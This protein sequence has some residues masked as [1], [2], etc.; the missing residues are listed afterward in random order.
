MISADRDPT[1]FHLALI[2]DDALE[3]D[4]LARVVRRDARFV[5]HTF[6]NA[7]QAGHVLAHNPVDLILLDARIPPENDPAASVATLRAAGIVTRIVVVSSALNPGQRS[8]DASVVFL[9]KDQ[10]TLAYLQRALS[11]RG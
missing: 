6:L 1:P 9:E 11:E 3:H 5:L 2:D 8:D 7:T 4:L 10:I